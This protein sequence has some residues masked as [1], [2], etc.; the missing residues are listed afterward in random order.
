MTEAGPYD[1]VVVG[2]G[3]VGASLAHHLTLRGLR[4]VLV[5]DRG[6]FSAE[7]AT[8]RSGGVLR[9]HHTA[10]ADT[11]LTVRSM[12]TF[13]GWADEV[14]GDCGYRRTGFVMI[15]AEEYAANLAKNTAAVQEAGGRAHLITADELTAEYPGL[16]LDRPAAVSYEP[17]GGYGD[18]AAATRALLRSAE[19]R[20][21]VLA[22]GLEVTGLTSAGER[23]TGVTTNLGPVHAPLVLLAAGAW[24]RPLAA[25]A[26]VDL[27]V[28][29]RRIG[30]ARHRATA[31]AG[32]VPAC[33]DDTLGRYFRPAD[34]D[35]LWFGAA[36]DPAVALDARP[37]ALR[38]DEVAT[39][40]RTLAE[41]VPALATG[42]VDGLR[43]GLDG[44]TPDHRPL[45]GPV[46][47]AGLYACTGF[48]G[49]GFKTAPAVGELVAAEVTS[50]AAEEWL[51]PYRPGRFA[52]GAPTESDFPYEHM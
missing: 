11:R 39:A 50:G 5:C 26:G 17:D 42:T 4:R 37:A 24:S 18:P 12:D 43:A 23:I 22:E 10:A 25:T 38:A 28:E 27:P 33:I 52:A 29:P 40:R 47:P 35:A 14:G 1:A 13:T 20:G 45:I 49:G 19:R 32:P 8:S 31:P 16:R 41:R 30:I 44:Y 3:V 48:S 6:R 7:G 15:V 51:A 2:G 36:A 34:G 46:G 21:A 9:Q